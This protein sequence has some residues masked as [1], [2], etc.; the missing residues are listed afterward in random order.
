M[1]S[2]L[3][4]LCNTPVCECVCVCVHCGFESVFVCNPWQA[5][6]M[7]VKRFDGMLMLSR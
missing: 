6:H 7:P 4:A 1:W 5:Q 3:I 2:Q